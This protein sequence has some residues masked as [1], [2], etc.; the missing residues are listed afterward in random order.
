MADQAQ[1][2]QHTIAP[3]QQL[4]QAAP[5]GGNTDEHGEAIELQNLSPTAGTNDAD[6][7]DHQQDQHSTLTGTTARSTSTWLTFLTGTV[8]D[9][10]VSPQDNWALVVLLLHYVIFICYSI[11]QVVLNYLNYKV[12]DK[13]NTEEQTLV[14]MQRLFGELAHEDAVQAH[15]DTGKLIEALSAQASADAQWETMLDKFIEIVDACVGFAV[16][17]SQCMV[18]PAILILC[19][20]IKHS[21]ARVVQMPGMR[22]T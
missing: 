2:E 18:N 19:D 1:L 20:R 12:S 17:L 8:S 13:P 5:L 14:K 16:S 9:A 11:I 10:F 4:P 22:P 3:P 7:P 15:K 21:T 6:V